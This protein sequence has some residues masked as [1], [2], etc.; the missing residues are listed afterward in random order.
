MT[1]SV[2]TS[3]NR[4]GNTSGMDLKSYVLDRGGTA[5]LGCSQLAYIAGRAD[6]SPATLYM[7]ATGNKKAG[8]KLAAAIELATSG[9]VLR[10]DL[11]PDIFGP[12]TKGGGNG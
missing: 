9:S 6:C 12:S 2:L 1:E 8:P 10:C 4:N 7:I 5:K 11:R 3:D